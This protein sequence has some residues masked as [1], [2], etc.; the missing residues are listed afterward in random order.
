MIKWSLSDSFFFFVGTNQIWQEIPQHYLRTVIFLNSGPITIQILTLIR[1]PC[2]I[3][4][5]W[6]GKMSQF[7]FGLVFESLN[8]PQTV[9]LWQQMNWFDMFYTTFLSVPW[10]HR[11][12]TDRKRSKPITVLYSITKVRVITWIHHDCIVEDYKQ[13]R[14]KKK[15]CLVKDYCYNH[16]WWMLK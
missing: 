15:P 11:S 5:S 10:T 2:E 6:H 3:L 16:G 9:D 13:D 4:F 7:T 1:V 8:K 14:V 12:G